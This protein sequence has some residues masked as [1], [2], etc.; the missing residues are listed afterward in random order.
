MSLDAIKSFCGSRRCRCGWAVSVS[1]GCVAALLLC[2]RLATLAF[3]LQSVTNSYDTSI[4]TSMSTAHL[5]LAVGCVAILLAALPAASGAAPQLSR[6][7]MVTGNITSSTTISV[8]SVGLA[9]GR[10]GMAHVAW[11]G[12]GEASTMPAACPAF[13]TCS[14]LTPSQP[15]TRLQC[16]TAPRAAVNTYPQGG[17]PAFSLRLAA[18]LQDLDRRQQLIRL[19]QLCAGGDQVHEHWWARVGGVHGG[20]G[21]SRV[22]GP[23]VSAAMPAASPHWTHHPT[24]TPRARCCRTPAPFIT[25]PPP[26][27]P[28]RAFLRATRTPRRPN[29]TAKPTVQEACTVYQAGI[30]NEERALTIGPRVTAP[31]YQASGLPLRVWVA[32]RGGSGKAGHEAGIQGHERAPPGP[33]R[34]PAAELVNEHRRGCPPMHHARTCAAPPHRTSS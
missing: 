5:L 9:E 12:G 24:P 21:G 6:R 17:L 34:P 30:A 25:P 33:A 11:G 2:A 14:Q 13:T 28:H 22:A 20:G 26:P 1:T 19:N 7:L 3:V 4:H 29:P 8:H 15:T 31:C 23:A 18:V 16:R 32:G 10:G 27:L